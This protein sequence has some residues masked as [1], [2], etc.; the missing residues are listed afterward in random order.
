MIAQ[1]P[2]NVFDGN[3]IMQKGVIIRHLILP[4]NIMQT[5]KILNWIKGNLPKDTYISVMAQY[6][7]TFEAKKHT[8]LN[9]KI[10]EKEYDLV[11]NMILDF[12]NGYIQELSDCEEEYVPNFDLSNI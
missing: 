8:L 1:Q 4:G 11:T 10:S 9:R 5:K 12:E 2:E 3:G 6:F 7:P